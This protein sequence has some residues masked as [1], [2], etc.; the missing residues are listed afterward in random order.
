MRRFSLTAMLVV[1]GCVQTETDTCGFDNDE[2]SIVAVVVDRGD[3]VR[4][5][6]DFEA[7][8]RKVDTTPLAVCEDETLRINDRSPTRTDKP[9][10]IVYSASLDAAE[11]RTVSFTLSRPDDD[12]VNVSIDLP[13]AFDVTAPAA[14]QMLSRAA[15]TVFTWDPPIPGGQMRIE[16]GEEIGGG[17]CIYTDEGDHHYKDIG[18]VDVPDD[19]QWTIPGGIVRSDEGGPCTASYTLKRIGPGEYPSSL[20]EGGFVEARV[21]RT[22]TFTSVD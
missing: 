15:D 18:G 7:G 6:I 1:T 14:G 4:A 11:T 17:I 13:G 5:E 3:V 20:S 16:L 19:G 2:L 22:I 8:D 21:E 10:R 9:E 12:T